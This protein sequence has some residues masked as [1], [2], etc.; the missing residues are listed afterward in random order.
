M[1]HATWDSHARC[2]WHALAPPRDAAT[3]RSKLITAQQ[4]TGGRVDHWK[5]EVRFLGTR[6]HT[7]KQELIP[8]KHFGPCAQMQSNGKPVIPTNN[9][10]THAF[11]YSETMCLSLRPASGADLL[12]GMVGQI[13]G[14][15][16]GEGGEGGGGG[17]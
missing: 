13:C 4:R 8:G 11:P 17:G 12:G 6:V 9:T 16:Q 15:R 3:W 10:Q 1:R 2:V 14:V 5:D 7:G